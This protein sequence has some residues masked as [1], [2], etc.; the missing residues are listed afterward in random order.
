MQLHPLVH[1]LDRERAFIAADLSNER[2]ALR[3]KAAVEALTLAKSD[4]AARKLLIA[5]AGVATPAILAT[6]TRT[7]CAK[8]PAD[9]ETDAA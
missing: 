3:I 2:A 8:T 4:T 7:E 9:A 6:D 1:E 5:I